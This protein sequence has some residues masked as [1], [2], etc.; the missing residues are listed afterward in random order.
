MVRRPHRHRK[1][2]LPLGDC[3][4]NGK[5]LCCPWKCHRS[6]QPL[7]VLI[8][9]AINKIWVSRSSCSQSPRHNISLSVC[10]T[11]FG[12][13]LENWL[14]SPLK[15]SWPLWSRRWGPGWRSWWRGAAA[16]KSRCTFSSIHTGPRGRRHRSPVA[17]GAG[18]ERREETAPG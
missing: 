15:N 13:C 18:T 9:V 8:L 14:N 11:H 2:L 10:Q 5:F 16:G 3:W 6:S 4:Q 7:L 12:S 17:A 1:A